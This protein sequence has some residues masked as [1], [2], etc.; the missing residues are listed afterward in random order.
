MNA[1]EIL[2]YYQDHSIAQTAK[3]FGV[4]FS[5]IQN[6]LA[7]LKATR[8]QREGMKRFHRYAKKAA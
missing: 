6:L 3:H 1:V 2:A 7:Q 8:S 5:R 4:P